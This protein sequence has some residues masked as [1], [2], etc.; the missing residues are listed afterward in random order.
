LP[1]AILRA[2][3]QAPK[4]FLEFFA[5]SIRNPNTR[6]AYFRAVVRFFAW[7]ER[8]GGTELSAIE[9]LHVAA[10]IEMRGKEVN[11]PSVKQELAA[12]R[13]LFDWLVVGG[14]GG[15]RISRQSRAPPCS[16]RPCSSRLVAPVSSRS[17]PCSR[18]RACGTHPVKDD[19]EP[20]LSFSLI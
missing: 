9:P 10:Y 18:R 14:I 13:I 17:S 12:V 3:E 15:R 19:S 2:S 16:R 4:R 20:E 7:C 6:R 5:G 8:R 11:K 1:A